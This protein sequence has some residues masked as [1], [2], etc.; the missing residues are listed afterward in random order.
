[1]ICFSVLFGRTL[2]DHDNKFEYPFESKFQ[3]STFEPS[4]FEVSKFDSTNFDDIKYEDPIVELSYDPYSAAEMQM[5]ALLGS[6]AKRDSLPGATGLGAS[7][8]GTGVMGSPSLYGKS[9]LPTPSSPSP[10]HRLSKLNTSLSPALS[11][12][13]QSPSLSDVMSASPATERRNPWQRMSPSPPPRDKWERSSP[14]AWF[15]T[16]TSPS[17]LVLY[18]ESYR[19]G[20]CNSNSLKLLKKIRNRIFFSYTLKY[21]R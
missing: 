4:K 11:R 18:M 16:R 21:V 15:P 6:P 14:N 12:R 1:M 17:R 10:K 20:P 19:F 5:Q 3:P 9:F 7:G 13:G 8:L 2:N